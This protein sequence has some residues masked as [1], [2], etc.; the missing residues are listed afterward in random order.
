MLR[1]VAVVAAGALSVGT[2]GCRL[3]AHRGLVT[4]QSDLWW[5]YPSVRVYHSPSSHLYWYVDAPGHWTQ[6]HELPSHLVVSGHEELRHSGADP[7]RDHEAHARRFGPSPQPTAGPV[8]G[9]SAHDQR[10]SGHG[11]SG[12]GHG[13]GRR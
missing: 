2:A 13:K 5:Y 8:A 11:R 7:W 10:R 12:S 9:P 1:I 4:V 6:A 3:F